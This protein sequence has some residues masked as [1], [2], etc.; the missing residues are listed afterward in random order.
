MKKLVITKIDSAQGPFMANIK[1]V[2]PFFIDKYELEKN[3][4]DLRYFNK[5]QKKQLFIYMI[6][7]IIG[8]AVTA[9]YFFGF[10]FL[11]EIL[12]LLKGLELFAISIE[13]GDYLATAKAFTMIILLLLQYIILLIL[14]I[15]RQNK[16]YLLKKFHKEKK[17]FSM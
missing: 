15:Q 14:M 13:T 11:R 17:V 6:I 2:I 1:R 4:D 7:V 16:L 10:V 8:L 3:S 9:I 5:T 12:Y